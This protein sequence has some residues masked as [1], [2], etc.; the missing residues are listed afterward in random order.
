MSVNVEPIAPDAQDFV[1][2]LE[3]EQLPIDDLGEN[4]RLF[5]RFTQNGM[6]VGFG[7]FEALGEHVLLRSIVVFPQFRG[8]GIGHLIVESLLE[9]AASLGAKNAYL[10][11]TSA[12]DFF[13]AIGFK[14]IGRDG[15]PPEILSTRQASSLCP[16]TATFLTRP[17][18]NRAAI[19]QASSTTEIIR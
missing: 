14:Q 11:T 9:H 13:E 10:L 8:Q 6:P 15:V 19:P 7:G 4:G 2:A 16:S 18:S 3:A 5:F 1:A 17:V 12:A